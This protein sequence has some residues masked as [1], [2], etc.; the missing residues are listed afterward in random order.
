MKKLFFSRKGKSP[1]QAMVEFAL[2]LPILLLVVYGLL[3]VGR[4]LFIYSSVVT[5][6]RSAARYGAT[7]G[8]NIAGGVLRY[9]DCA[10]MRAEAKKVAFLDRFEDD[11]IAIDWDSGEATSPQTQYEPEPPGV[12]G[13]N[14]NDYCSPGSATDTSFT[15]STGNSQRIRVE[16]RT[17]YSPI[18]PLVPLNPFEIR[19]VSARTILVSVPI[20]I[21][22]APQ[23]W[24]P[25]TP[26]PPPPPSETA[27]EEPTP[28]STLEDT[29]T[30]TLTPTLTLTPTRTGTPTKTGTPTNTGSPTTTG[31][32]TGT[33][34]PC[35]VRR[36]DLK[37]A[38][39]GMTI[40]NNN[41]LETLHIVEIQIYWNPSSPAGQA[42]TQLSLGGVTVWS[43]S[44]TGSPAI[45]SV[46]TGDISILPA[47]NKLLQ[48]S[49]A[50][51]YKDDGSERIIIS[52]AENGCPVL[53][54]SDPNQSQ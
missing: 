28:T 5:A 31:T 39:F 1:A 10:G 33:A 17:L 54:S 48:A 43:G 46:F 18:V 38:P 27:T 53:D 26:P 42:L 9:Q 14:I 23:T 21:T 51:N 32:P 34:F 3:E 7:T 19:S 47:T 20:A 36:S 37:T 16:V 22:A 30:P 24:E 52:F 35:E 29:P 6:A 13:T 44:T 50:K 11:D 49:F 45:F 25:P 41:T 2:V 4:L 8:V 12:F 15:A 40:F